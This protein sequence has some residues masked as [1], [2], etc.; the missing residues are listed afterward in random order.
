[1]LENNFP[2]PLWKVLKQV[3]KGGSELPPSTFANT[4]V[5]SKCRLGL[6]SL[7][8]KLPLGRAVRAMGSPTSLRIPR[9]KKLGKLVGV[10][11]GLEGNFT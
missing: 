3:R 4:A 1:M 7:L 11:R 9:G 10:G 8:A 5:R 2:E 6:G